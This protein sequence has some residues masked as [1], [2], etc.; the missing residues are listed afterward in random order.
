VADRS[1][2]RVLEF[3]IK[4]IGASPVSNGKGANSLSISTNVTAWILLP[5]PTNTIY[6]GF[7]AK[8]AK[9]HGNTIQTTLATTSI[10]SS[11]PKSPNG[12]D[13]ILVYAVVTVIIVAAV[14]GLVLLKAAKKRK[15][16][17][18]T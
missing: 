12:S 8:I 4:S 7:A 11:Y 16:S 17:R 2:S 13:T 15:D 1:N 5:H 10:A 3:L 6:L 18:K 9:P 14:L